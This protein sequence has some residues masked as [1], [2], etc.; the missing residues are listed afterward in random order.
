M[1]P[2]A[3]FCDFDGTISAGETFV[4]VL[5]TYAPE[6]APTLIPQILSF[7]VTLREGVTRMLQTMPSDRYDEAIASAD[8]VPLRA[9]LAELVAWCG[10]HDVPFVVVSGGLEDMVRRKLGPLES[11]VTGVHAVRIDRSGPTWRVDSPWADG[12]ELVG[13]I[14]VMHAHPA[15]ERVAIGDSATDVRMSEVAEVVFARDRLCTYLDERGVDYLPW[16]DFHDIRRALAAR[17]GLHAGP[18]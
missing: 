2:R 13:K 10:E 17:W 4:H 15:A 3:V 8:D 7:E 18:S 5:K 14:K 16:D 6:L 1:H 11:R 9:G 12:P